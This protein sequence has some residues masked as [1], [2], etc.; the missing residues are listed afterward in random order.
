[1]NSL[2]YNWGMAGG[3]M[4]NMIF[5]I[6]NLVIHNFMNISPSIPSAIIGIMN[7]NIS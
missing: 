2:P 1:M 5:L 6:V 4:K 7:T 3:K